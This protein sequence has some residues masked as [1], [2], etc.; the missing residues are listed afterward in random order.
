M[1]D[2]INKSSSRNKPKNSIWSVEVKEFGR[3]ESARVEMAPLVVLLGKNNTGKS[4][5]ATLLWSILNFN[6]FYEPQHLSNDDFPEWFK[7]FV[8]QK[9]AEF[10][11]S[12]TIKKK[13]FETFINDCIAFRKNEVA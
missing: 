2:S 13:D 6:D 4:Y 8:A 3:I 1:T 5:L 11:G 7:N 9:P 10:S 12:F